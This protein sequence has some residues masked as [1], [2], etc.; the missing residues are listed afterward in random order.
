MYLLEITLDSGINVGLRLLFLK[1]LEEKK[2][3]ND[4]NA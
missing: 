1:N 3:K 4:S 2:N